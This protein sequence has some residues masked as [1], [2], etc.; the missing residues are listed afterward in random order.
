[1]KTNAGAPEIN[2][3]KESDTEAEETDEAMQTDNI[4]LHLLCSRV[5]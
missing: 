1:M 5:G 3:E 4:T 2:E